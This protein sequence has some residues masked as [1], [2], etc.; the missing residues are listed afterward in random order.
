MPSGKHT[1]PEQWVQ[2]LLLRRAGESMRQA[3]IKSDVNYYSARDNEAGRTSTRAWMQAKEQ[4]DRIGVS[5]VPEYHELDPEAQEAFDNIEAF[6]LR[7]FGIILQPWQ[8]EAT[9]QVNALLNTPQEEYIVINAP[10]GSG[11]STFLPKYFR[12]GPRSVTVRF[13]A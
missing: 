10:P 11:K 1:T 13:A 8:I 7:Y 9:E 2:Y 6:A 5:K 3:A 12:R 4:V